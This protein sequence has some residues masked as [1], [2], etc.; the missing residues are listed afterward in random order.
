M[1]NSSRERTSKETSKHGRR[2]SRSRDRVRHKSPLK[3]RRSRSYDARSD[4]YSYSDYSYSDYSYSDSPPRKR[5]VSPLRPIKR[6]IPSDDVKDPRPIRER[7]PLPDLQMMRRMMQ[8]IHQSN[9]NAEIR[10][11]SASKRKLEVVVW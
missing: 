4:S 3:G 11:R 2:R 1:K 9:Q 5:S 6:D 7:L 10:D 8:N